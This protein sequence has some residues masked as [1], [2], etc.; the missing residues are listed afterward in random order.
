MVNKGGQCGEGLNRKTGTRNLSA[1]LAQSSHSFP[2]RS[3]NKGNN[4]ISNNKVC[5]NGEDTARQTVCFDPGLNASRKSYDG[6]RLCT[7]GGIQCY[8]VHAL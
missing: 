4:G 8:M 3:L 5:G 2:N 1:R 6:S 7:N